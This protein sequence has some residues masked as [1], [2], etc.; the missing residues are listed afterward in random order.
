MKR[1]LFP[2]L[3][4]GFD[5]LKAHRE[6]K[7]TLRT[8]AVECN[9]TILDIVGERRRVRAGTFAKKTAVYPGS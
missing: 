4:R 1:K 2:E 5:A 6:G 7:R 8:H 9:V 3:A